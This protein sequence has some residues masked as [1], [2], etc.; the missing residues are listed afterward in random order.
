MDKIKE[1]IIQE[2]GEFK[3]GITRSGKKKL[4]Y[5][6]K[7]KREAIY[8]TLKFRGNKKHTDRLNYM[9]KLNEKVLRFLITQEKEK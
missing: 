6:I 7:G 4:A 8:I 9:L 5:R 1:E 2:G 3:G